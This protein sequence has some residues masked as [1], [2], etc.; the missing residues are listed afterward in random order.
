MTAQRGHPVW[1][2][3]ERAI[4]RLFKWCLLEMSHPRWNRQWMPS[5][6]FLIQSTCP[7]L[8]HYTSC[9]TKEHAVLEFTQS[10]SSAEARSP[11]HHWMISR[12]GQDSLVRC[13]GR[14]PIGRSLEEVV[15]P[16]C[17]GLSSHPAHLLPGPPWKVPASCLLCHLKSLYFN[18]LT[19]MPDISDTVLRIVL[20]AATRYK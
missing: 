15:H 10:F 9:K 12:P 8:P 18:C 13:P 11:S 17:A 6:S 3:I 1:L 16:N 7:R 5:F 20:T 14:G 2:H 4:W 19:S